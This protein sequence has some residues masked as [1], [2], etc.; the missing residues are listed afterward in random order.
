MTINLELLPNI[1]VLH[2]IGCDW[3]LVQSCVAKATFM[4][5]RAMLA[6]PSQQYYYFFLIKQYNSS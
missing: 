3:L 4:T 2:T 5:E 6:L 1:T